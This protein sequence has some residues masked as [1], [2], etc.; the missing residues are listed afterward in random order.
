MNSKESQEIQQV[1]DRCRNLGLRCTS[2]V[3]R[4]IDLFVKSGKPLTTKEI[5]DSENIASRFDQ[6]SVYRLITRLEQRGI[7]RRIGMLERSAYFS[8][9]HHHQCDDYI[10]CTTCGGIQKLEMD[11]PVD[12]VQKTIARASGYRNLE[13]E[14]KFFGI[15][16]DCQNAE[17]GSGS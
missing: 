14:L 2:L 16:P 3:N 6:A 1:L 11:C 15:C 12:S 13:H 10:V 17:L 4:T 9:R 8:L 5:V 7:V